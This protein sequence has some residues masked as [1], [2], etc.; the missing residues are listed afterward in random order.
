M[1]AHRRVE[2]TIAE[3]ATSVEKVVAGPV[4]KTAMS[5]CA[6]ESCGER[7]AWWRG[8]KTGCHALARGDAGWRSGGAVAEAA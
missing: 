1:E 2:F 6:L 3:L 7:K 5:P 4:K 8:R